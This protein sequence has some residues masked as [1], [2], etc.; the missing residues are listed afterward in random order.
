M[1]PVVLAGEDVAAQVKFAAGYGHN[2]E[3]H[4]DEWVQAVIE[5]GENQSQSVKPYK[6][7]RHNS[8]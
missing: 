2:D 6:Q 1:K 4:D 8:T 5:Q 3:R 7:E